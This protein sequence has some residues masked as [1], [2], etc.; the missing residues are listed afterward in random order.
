MTE[1]NERKL[2]WE[3]IQE[4]KIN[5]VKERGSRVMKINSPLGATLFTILRQFDMAYAHF[6]SRL[7]EMG[8]ISYKDGEALM[9]EGREIVMAFSDFTDRLSR[10]IHFR[11]FTPREISEFLKALDVPE[12]E[13]PCVID[14]ILVSER[15]KLA[16]NAKNST[17][18]EETS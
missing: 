16:R 15:E 10:K 8:G 1:P 7:G 17:N 18:S 11:Y 2:T 12:D 5:M 13:A 4:K 9:E 3:E 6:K 14:T